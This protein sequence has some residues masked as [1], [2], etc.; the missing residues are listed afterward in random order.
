MSQDVPIDRLR[1]YWGYESF[2]P[3]QREAIDCVL[4]KQ[5][6][7]VVLPT[8]G[9][10]SIC[11][12]VPALCS[13]DGLA[14][15]VSPLISL[16]KDQVDGL[17]AS[18]IAAASLNSTL[19]TEDKSRVVREIR[20]GK[21]RLLYVSPERLV[22]E[23]TIELLQQSN[24]RFFAIDEAHCIS[25]WGHD[26]RP[27]YRQLSSLKEKFPATSVHAFTATA[28]P[29]VRNDIAEQ[30]H[31]QEAEKL[32]GSFYR[33]NLKYRVQR[34]TDAVAQIQ[35]VIERYPDQSGIIYCISRKEVENV[36]A[37]LNSQGYRTRAYH[38]GLSATDRSQNQDDF[39]NEKVDIIVATVAFGMGI[40]KSSVRYVIHNGMP[41]S[42]EA[43]QQESGRAGRDGLPSECCLL[44][45]GSDLMLWK[46][47]SDGQPSS[48]ELLE[49][50]YGYCTRTACRHR[51][52]VEYFGQE[53]EHADCQAC[54]ICLG[55]REQVGEP[56]I[57]AQKIISC[58]YRV[59]QRFGT[60]HVAAVLLG[61]KSKRVL[62]LKHDQ[63]ST[64]GLL[65]EENKRALIDWIEQLT[66]QG[67]LQ[68]SGEY[69][70]LT[71]TELGSQVLR[72]EVTPKLYQPIVESTPSQAKTK[73]DP[74]WSDAQQGLFDD[75]RTYRR[76][77]SNERG[78]PPFVIFHDA[79]L[80]DMARVRPSGAESFSQI[81][82]VGEKKLKDYGDGF[83][84]RIR[85][86]CETHGLDQDHTIEDAK[87][88]SR[89]KPKSKT[90]VGPKQQ[91][92]ELFA[93][94][95]SVSEVA[96][97][98]GR[99]PSTTCKYLAE[100]I[101]LNHITDPTSWVEQEASEQIRKAAESVGSLERMAPI[102]E[103]LGDDFSYEQI[104]IVVECLRVETG[105]DTSI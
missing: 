82:G 11:Y 99:A 26:F 60:H 91:A 44:F 3:L 65:A 79:S 70:V 52:L 53:F 9:G 47:M 93:A 5:D 64:Y 103:Q 40:D 25:S 74:S 95:N 10:K 23:G 6:S 4:S 104:Q 61:S 1:K 29:R 78:L 38:A 27:E 63:L 39:I 30:L 90:Q 56:L 86:Y 88:A 20:Q 46:R 37:T 59:N 80:R 105:Y 22:Q 75:L 68:K 62:E 94:G 19:S 43:Y 100:Y 51:M 8:G 35:E 7:V 33:S 32:V 41:K 85:L 87:P 49:A 71:I 97:Q 2:R 21:L 83:V 17:V 14:V 28:T 48:K 42:L 55:D 16:M 57:L 58:V 101:R 77:L 81:Q 18:G 24:V 73:I 12:Q 98:I 102:R 84:D 45:S 69:N 72:G 13:E 67:Y 31:L 54:D 76:E 89:K 92:F 50:M 36:A 34:R 15:V 66:G 96:S